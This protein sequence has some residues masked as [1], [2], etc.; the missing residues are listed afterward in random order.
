[1]VHAK[2]WKKGQSSSSNPTLKKHREAAKNNLFN[3]KTSD[4]KELGFI[5]NS[6]IINLI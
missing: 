5:M 4:S 3:Y 2:R 6:L 1:M